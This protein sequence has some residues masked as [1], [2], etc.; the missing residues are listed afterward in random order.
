MTTQEMEERLRAVCEMRKDD[1][2]MPPEKRR[3]VLDAKYPV[4]DVWSQTDL[5]DRIQSEVN[6]LAY[7]PSPQLISTSQFFCAADIRRLSDQLY[8]KQEM[9]GVEGTRCRNVIEVLRSYVMGA[10]KYPAEVSV[11]DKLFHCA[12]DLA[13]TEP[14]IYEGPNGDELLERQVRAARRLRPYITEEWEILDGQFVVTQTVMEQLQTE[15]ERRI[16]RMGGQNLL[17]QLHQWELQPRY[18]ERLDR[19]LLVRPK[20]GGKDW[21][22]LP[23]SAIPCNYLIHL[24]LKHL[25]PPA[26]VYSLSSRGYD[27]AISYARDMMTVMNLSNPEGTYEVLLPT[28][29]MIRFI[30][31]GS[32]YDSLCIPFQYSPGFCQFAAE[33]LY[34]P[35]M[36]Q[37]KL[38]RE[39]R[40][41]PQVLRWC[42]G[43]RPM[44]HFTVE[45]VKRATGLGSSQIESVLKFCAQDYGQVNRGFCSLGDRAESWDYPLI[46]L[47]EGNYLQVDPHFCGYAFCECLYRELKSR[48]P[49]F[50]RKLGLEIE[51]RV[52]ELLDAKSMPYKSG[53]YRSAAG[54]QGECDLILEG[55]H[56]IL[57]LELKKRPLPEGFQQGDSVEILRALGEG[58]VYGQI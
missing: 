3:E 16:A 6:K 49:V 40:A 41:F 46:R 1:F 4:E 10:L 50:D 27:A 13:L 23:Q 47:P 15:L 58:M 28:D 56:N 25:V 19:Y 43:L 22:K 30:T 20:R 33:Q 14:S 45:D 8:L 7:K 11:V 31:D 5:C 17:R 35:F 57:F 52:K 54:T 42:L 48:I 21:T 53:N 24:A 51:R 32:Q 34:L 9:F 36:K 39:A 37:A 29:L 12:V 2:A 55:K 18:D 26:G 38:V 44:T